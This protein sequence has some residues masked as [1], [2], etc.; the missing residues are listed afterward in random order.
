MSV[1]ATGF[2]GVD[3][4]A[5]VNYVFPVVLLGAW[6]EVV[7]VDADPVVALVADYFGPVSVG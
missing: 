5:P 6:L 3:V 4:A 7:G 2:V 1:G